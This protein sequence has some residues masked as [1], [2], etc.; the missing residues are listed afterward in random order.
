MPLFEEIKAKNKTAINSLNLKTGDKASTNYIKD[1]RFKIALIKKH[2]NENYIE[3][4]NYPKAS[5]KWLL[6]GFNWKK[7]SDLRQRIH[8]QRHNENPREIEKNKHHFFNQKK[9]DKIEI[10]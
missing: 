8:N 6:E 7:N 2:F 9:D 1:F 5:F 4:D 10:V 3:N